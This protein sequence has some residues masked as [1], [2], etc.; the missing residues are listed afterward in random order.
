M[1]LRATLT[2]LALAAHALAQAAVPDP[3][4]T[5]P[6][7]PAP[8]APSRS[9]T[10]DASL[11]AQL[12]GALTPLLVKH[13]VPA[14]AVAL[15]DR[16]R[17]IARAAS[18]LRARG[19]PASVTTADRWHIG[20]CTKAFTSTVLGALVDQGQLAW[21]TTLADA[22]P[23]A[24]V[25]MH[26]DLKKVTL[27]QLLRHRAGL[28]Q[29]TAGNSPDF[30]LLKGLPGDTVRDQRAAFVEKLL[31]LGPVLPP[32]TK[33]FYSNA[34]YAVAAAIAERAAGRPYDALLQDHVF[35]RLAITHAGLGWP[36]TPTRRDEPRGH[37]PG[38]LGARPQEFDPKY[39]LEPV[40]APAGD[41]HCTIEELAAFARAHLDALLEHEKASPPGTRDRPLI[42]KPAT[43]AELHEPVDG[44]AA[45]WA[46]N[47]VR[48]QTRHWHNGSAGTFFALMVIIPE[49]RLGAVAVSN[50]G[51]AEKA[52]VE[53]IETALGLAD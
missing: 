18:G 53:I 33:Q 16:E 2:A 41:I 47:T 28:P 20:S 10:L 17:V 29:F 35:A 24:A 37:L 51:D 52:C 44:Y 49:R 5:N 31:A 6:L 39:K 38:I 12:K 4:T 19:D 50:A 43:V 8:P 32:D 34:G 23:E 26:H 45:G 14:V 25:H 3:S 30:D 48:K 9:P 7:S 46:V 40:L 1:I 22:L 36:A 11:D 27:R 21:D 13:K 42:L 15:F